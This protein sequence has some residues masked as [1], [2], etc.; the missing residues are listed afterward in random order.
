MK[1]AIVS[2]GKLGNRWDAPYH[3][4]RAANRTTI[5]RLHKLAKDN[6]LGFNRLWR[7]APEHREAL[8]AVVRGT[9]KACKQDL[10]RYS[11]EERITFLAVALKDI[12]DLEAEAEKKETEAK[13]LREQKAQI[14]DILR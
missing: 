14:E 1:I 5:E 10:S 12:G 4:A 8:E 3:L 11:L 6:P 2:S 7:L 13:V 9:R